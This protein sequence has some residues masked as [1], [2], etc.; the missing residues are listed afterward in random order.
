[1]EDDGATDVIDT[2]TDGTAPDG[3]FSAPAGV[4]VAGDYAFVTNTAFDGSDNSFGPGFVTVVR[5]SDFTVVNKISTSHRNP[6]AIAS[7]GDKVFV[8]CSGTTTWDQQT[9]VVSP[10][11]D[12]SIEVI[13]VE[14]APTA[15]E[16][17]TVI[18]L[19]RSTEFPLLG[20]PSTLAVVDN[21]SIAYAGCGTTAAVF[22]FDLEGKD[23][24]RGTDNPINLGDLAT[25]DSITVVAGPPGVLYAGSYN[26]DRV[27][28]IDTASDI[29]ASAPFSFID[30]G[31]DASNMDGVLHMVHRYGKTPDL[32]VLLNLASTVQGV[33]TAK[34]QAGVETLATTGS[35][36]NRI[37]A[38]EDTLYIVN[39]GENNVTAFDIPT[40]EP[41]DN[42][43]VFDTD[44]NPYDMTVTEVDG[45]VRMYV[46]GNISNSLFEANPK[47]STVLREVR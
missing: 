27:Y 6:Q 23:V 13:D 37:A 30:V 40:R 34:G 26:R 9:G 35:V 17:Q 47:D 16:P 1:M 24:L 21:G 12:A 29:Q 11:S 39:S 10:S 42:A 38:F 41:L 2:S 31:K 28:A 32:L 33:T 3:D 44:T 18:S 43:A 46:T 25:Q 36:P 20:Y 7:V 4:V 15:L 45:D 14:S 22:K 19:P 5:L 8:L